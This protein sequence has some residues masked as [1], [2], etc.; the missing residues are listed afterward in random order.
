SKWPSIVLPPAATPPRNA[1]SNRQTTD[2]CC[3]L[4]RMLT[5]RGC[6]ETLLSETSA[7]G[8]WRSCQS[9]ANPSPSRGDDET[10]ILQAPPVPARYD[11]S[12]GLALF[13]VHDEPARRR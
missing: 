2:S 11:P 9:N 12:G 8:R 5:P 3:G 1:S 6:A 7:G 10:D 13:S 4:H